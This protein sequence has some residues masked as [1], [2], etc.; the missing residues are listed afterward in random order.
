M[1]DDVKQGAGSKDRVRLVE[2]N[3][4][5]FRSDIDG[6]IQNEFF[7]T[8]MFREFIRVDADAVFMQ[9]L[10]LVNVTFS[11]FMETCLFSTPVDVAFHCNCIN[12]D[13]KS[14][15]H[16]SEHFGGSVN[17]YLE[18]FHCYH[19]LKIRSFWATLSAVISLPSPTPHDH[20]V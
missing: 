15:V 11:Y 18:R 7:F 13:Q 2:R 1:D 19:G 12:C 10:N 14:H 5:F 9:L 16:K 17:C 6:T 8:K 4:T 20:R 3:C